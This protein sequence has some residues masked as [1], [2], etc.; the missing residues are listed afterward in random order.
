MS[1]YFAALLRAS[2]LTGAPVAAPSGDAG[3]QVVDTFAAPPPAVGQTTTPP[4]SP[5]AKPIVRKNIEPATAAEVRATVTEA[6]RAPVA[7]P[8]LGAPQPS[9]PEAITAAEQPVVTQQALLQS[10]LQWVASDP[11][12]PPEVAISEPAPHREAAPTHV[13]ISATAQP[14]PAVPLPSPT[15]L[16]ALNETQIIV[17]ANPVA[18]PLPAPSSELPAANPVAT[19]QTPARAEVNAE[20]A[21]QPITVSIGAIHLRVDAPAAPAQPAAAVKP[22]ATKTVPTAASTTPTRSS[23]SRRALRSF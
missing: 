1:D 13:Q 8:T 7:Q 14:A 6:S 5:A 18:K 19:L 12:Q 10:V 9:V 15:V 17:A 3:L 21:E 16:A 11:Q 20:P 4:T 23:L 22:A 2:G